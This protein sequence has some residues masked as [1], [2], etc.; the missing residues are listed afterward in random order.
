MDGYYPAQFNH[1]GGTSGGDERF[2]GKRTAA[3]PEA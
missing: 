2:D 3:L 1:G